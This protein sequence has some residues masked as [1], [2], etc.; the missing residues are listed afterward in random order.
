MGAKKQKTKT[1]DFLNSVTFDEVYNYYIIENHSKPQCIEHFKTTERIFRAFLAYYSLK[2]PRSLVHNLICD[3]KEL[4]YGDP[5]Y[6]NQ[7]KTK[8]TCLEKYG[9]E[10]PL[11]NREIWQKTFDTTISK[12]G[13]TGFANMPK[14]KMVAT[15]KKA[16]S[17]MWEKYHLDPCFKET[18]QAS[19]NKTK[20]ANK[21]FNTTKRES[22]LYTRLV[23]IYGEQDVIAQYR[24]IR[25]PYNCDF[26]IKSLDLFIELNAHWTHGEHPF[27][28]NNTEDL[29]KL[30]V[31]QEKS[32]ESKFFTNAI[33][34]WTRRDVEKL[35]ILQENKLNF[36]LIYNKMEVASSDGYK[37]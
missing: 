35:N 22:E 31:W 13:G 11:E 19:Q 6:N 7:E 15:A 2:K 8:Q 24:D 9:C 3:T 27:D 16:N 30:T 32:K 23:T 20:K 10:S 37:Y 4:K 28:K 21:T 14:A 36:V 33:E 12:Y 25:Y 1:I 29:Q 5:N 26:Y 18:Y 34:T 17:A